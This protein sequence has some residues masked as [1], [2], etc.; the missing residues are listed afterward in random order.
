[1]IIVSSRS[2]WAGSRQVDS[3]HD[4]M[5]YGRDLGPS[6]SSNDLSRRRRMQGSHNKV[7]DVSSE[8]DSVEV[9]AAIDVH[10]YGG[11]RYARSDTESFMIHR[12]HDAQQS[13]REV[14]CMVSACYRRT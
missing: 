11:P 6:V 10:Y 12:V 2:T 5:Q 1:M 14:G 8:K 9:L 13:G 3:L 7:V 4:L